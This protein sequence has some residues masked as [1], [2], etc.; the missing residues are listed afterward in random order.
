MDQQAMI[1]H[2]HRWSQI[3]FWLVIMV[4]VL[5][6]IAVFILTVKR[7]HIEGQLRELREQLTQTE[8]D[9][10]RTRSQDLQQRLVEAQQQQRAR[11]LTQAQVNTL[12][13]RLQNGPIGRIRLY[14][15]TGDAEAHQFAR[16]LDRVIAAGRWPTEGVFELDSVGEPQVGLTIERS[17]VDPPGELLLRT[18]REFELEVSAKINPDV[19]DGVVWLIVG[20]KP[21]PQR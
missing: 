7:Q 21:S 5:A 8:L 20:Q 12:V 2:L 4:P 18:L 10:L 19:A 13:T 3:Y 14:A 6:A 9:A 17:R 1:E 11:T 15:Q 16:L